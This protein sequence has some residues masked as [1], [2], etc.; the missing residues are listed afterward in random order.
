MLICRNVKGVRGQR[1]FGN[2]LFRSFRR[3][4]ACV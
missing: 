1:K 4:L 2:P 3:N